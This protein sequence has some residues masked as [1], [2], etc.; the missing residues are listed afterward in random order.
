MKSLTERHIRLA[1]KIDRR[2]SGYTDSPA[3]TEALIAS[4]YKVLPHFRKLMFI[5]N[6]HQFYLLSEKY[7]HFERGRT[8][9]DLMRCGLTKSAPSGLEN[10]FSVWLK[11]RFPNQAQETTEKS[12]C[13]R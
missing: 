6:E 1:E 10:T 11:K 7:K 4:I 9:L 13:C 5:T 2:V 12:E 8:M 3:D